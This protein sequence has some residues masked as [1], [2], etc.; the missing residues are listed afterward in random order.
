M[1]T[2]ANYLRD[3]FSMLMDRAR[4]ASHAAKGVRDAT[5]NDG[6]ELGRAQG[7]YEVLSTMLNQL[8]AFD[9]SRESLGLTR[10]LNLERE[11]L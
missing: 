7:Y 4:A 9:I 2:E 5:A 8:D 6:F 10:D 3:L 1:S 11:L